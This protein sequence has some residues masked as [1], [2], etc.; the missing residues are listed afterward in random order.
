VTKNEAQELAYA[1]T[2]LGDAMGCLNRK[3][4]SL[5]STRMAQ[6]AKRIRKLLHVEGE[7]EK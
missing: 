5:V 6:A 3:V 2:E 4:Y 7:D 1:L